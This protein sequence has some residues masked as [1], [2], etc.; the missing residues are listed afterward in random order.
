MI[1]HECV[2][3]IPALVFYNIKN[4]IYLQYKENYPLEKFENFIVSSF[5]YMSIA[6]VSHEIV[7][8]HK[9]VNSKKQFR[10]K[11]YILIN[12]FHLLKD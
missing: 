2:C 3:I 9:I 6:A 12:D 1:T 7:H 11:K 10:Q 5:P 4:I 8:P